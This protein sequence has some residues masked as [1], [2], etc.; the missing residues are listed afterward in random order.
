MQPQPG[1]LLT[2]HHERYTAALIALPL[3]A[4]RI[5][6]SR[7]FKLIP[8]AWGTLLA[9]RSLTDSPNSRACSSIDA[10]SLTE[11]EGEVIHLSPSKPLVTDKLACRG[12]TLK[13][14]GGDPQTTQDH[15]TLL[16]YLLAGEVLGP[17]HAFTVDRGPTVFGIYATALPGLLQLTDASVRLM[18]AHFAPAS[19]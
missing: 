4:V 15:G 14:L 17:S 18:C 5:R 10:G 7:T 8:G 6:S 19:S 16:L 3:G 11:E 12:A 13:F 9:S 2:L 1:Q